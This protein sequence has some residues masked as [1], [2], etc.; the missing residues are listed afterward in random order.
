MNTVLLI[1]GGVVVFVLLSRLGK[2]QNE[3]ANAG[4]EQI[5]CPHCHQRGM[6]TVKLVTRGKGISGGKAAGAVMTG[7][8]SVGA[9]GLSRNE[10]ARQLTCGNCKMQWDVA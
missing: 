1:A 3:E 7:G 5:V 9:T 4:A 8:L 6:V 2:A 10:K